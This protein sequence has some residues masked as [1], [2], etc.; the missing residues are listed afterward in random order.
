MEC[1][2]PR[3]K[4]NWLLQRGHSMP[5]ERQVLLAFVHSLYFISAKLPRI[6][7]PRVSLSLGTVTFRP[8][9]FMVVGLACAF[10]DAQSRPAVSSHCDNLNLSGDYQLSPTSESPV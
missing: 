2:C 6:F 4:G 5:P 10:Y 8:E 1:V 7:P 9:K 3:E